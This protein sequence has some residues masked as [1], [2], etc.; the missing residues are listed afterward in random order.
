MGLVGSMHQVPILGPM[1]WARFFPTAF[2]GVGVLLEGS[3][4]DDRRTSAEGR[5][6]AEAGKSSSSVVSP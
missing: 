6:V 2:D 1:R 3:E 4:A 5:A